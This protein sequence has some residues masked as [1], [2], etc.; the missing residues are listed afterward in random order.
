M[1]L[2]AYGTADV[3]LDAAAI[4]GAI[5]SGGSIIGRRHVYL[6]LKSI[7]TG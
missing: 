3:K 6:S 1:V 7:C 2:L 4:Y 5:Y